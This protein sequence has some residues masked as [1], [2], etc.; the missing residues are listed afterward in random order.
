MGQQRKILVTADGRYDL[1]EYQWDDNRFSDLLTKGNPINTDQALDISRFL[2]EEISKLASDTITTAVIEKLIGAKMSEYG[3][4][5]PTALH[6][7]KS[8]FVKNGPTLSGN[9][10]TVLEL[11][12][13]HI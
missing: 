8:I 1:E 12:L 6:L 4:T 2:R 3:F 13:I 9:A 7:D 11:S 5:Q 10:K